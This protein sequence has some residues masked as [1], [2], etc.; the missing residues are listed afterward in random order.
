MCEKNSTVLHHQ[1][2]QPTPTRQK[3]SRYEM[4]IEQYY[5]LRAKK[6]RV[7]A[8]SAP[9]STV[10]VALR[11]FL[12]PKIRFGVIRPAEIRSARPAGGPHFRPPGPVNPPISC[13]FRLA[14]RMWSDQCDWVRKPTRF[15]TNL[16]FRRSLLSCVCSGLPQALLVHRWAM[17][18]DGFGG[19][20][21]PNP[22]TTTPLFT[23]LTFT[24]KVMFEFD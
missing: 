4:K 20:M 22:A 11:L 15:H 16:R 18:S 7:R 2:R 24:F 12:V 19:E 5:I 8:K 23:L 21:G 10:T 9:L 17:I 6:Q 14:M 3:S 13:K 1:Q